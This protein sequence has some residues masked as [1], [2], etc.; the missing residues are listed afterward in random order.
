ME[1]VCESNPVDIRTYE[2]EEG[3]I[4]GTFLPYMRYLY[5]PG[6]NLTDGG[7]VSELITKIY[8]SSVSVMLH[9]LHN[10]LGR[11]VHVK[12]LIEEGL[13]DYL[14]ALPWNV[15][16]SSSDMAR[17]M[18]KDVGKL[19]PIKPPSLCSLAKAKLAKVTMGLRKVMEMKSVSDLFLTAAVAGCSC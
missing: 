2:I 10:A 18:L 12:I 16:S 11:E 1:T 6:I 15:A 14:V 17:N 5:S 4:W 19:T 3:L 7:G 8:Q 13:L 9:S